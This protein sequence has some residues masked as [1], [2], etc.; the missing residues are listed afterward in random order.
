VTNKYANFCRKASLVVVA[1]VLPQASTAQW[2]DQTQVLSQE[3]FGYYRQGRVLDAIN[4]QKRLIEAIDSSQNIGAAWSAVE[5]MY[6][7]CMQPGMPGYSM[8][9]SDLECTN[10]VY[11][12]MVDLPSLGEDLELITSLRKSY[13]VSL[14]LVA[15]EMNEYLPQVFSQGM[16][17]SNDS[18][19]DVVYY[20]NRQLL[21]AEAHLAMDNSRRARI[22]LERALATVLSIENAHNNIYQVSRWLLGISN[23]YLELNDIR[24][25]QALFATAGP[26][27]VSSFA[28]NSPDSLAAYAFGAR[29]F[30]QALRPEIALS[31]IDLLLMAVD[32]IDPDGDRL[33]YFRDSAF[34]L[35]IAAC[36]VSDNR[37]CMTQA[38]SDEKQ[39]ARAELALSNSDDDFYYS[40]LEFVAARNIG[41][42]MMGLTN[43]EPD[44]RKT[45]TFYEKHLPIEQIPQLDVLIR[46]ALGLSYL[47]MGDQD[48]AKE[49][50]T[51]ATQSSISQFRRDASSSLGH[52]P[53]PPNEQLIMWMMALALGIGADIEQFGDLKNIIKTGVRVGEDYKDL[54]IAMAAGLERSSLE[55]EG[56]SL[57]VIA[58]ANSAQDRQLA[59]MYLRTVSKQRNTYVQLAKRL[60]DDV[61]AEA[62][63]NPNAG[64][65]SLTMD[66]SIRR[67]VSDYAQRRIELLGH[68][69]DDFKSISALPT[70]EDIQG[71]LGEKEALLLETTFGGARLVVCVRNDVVYLGGMQLANQQQ[72]YLDLRV[73][74]LA[75]EASHAPSEKLDRQFPASA[76][77]R[78]YEQLLGP[79]EMC[80]IPGDTVYVAAR[81][82]GLPYEML[83]EY[84]PSKLGDGF[85]L[86]TAPWALNKYNFTYVGTALEFVAG[87]RID[88]DSGASTGFLGVGNPT[89]S[90][91]T[92]DGIDRE[93]LVLRGALESASESLNELPPLPNTL[94][95]LENIL[96]IMNGDGTVITGDSATEMTLRKSGVGNFEYLSF[97]THGLI[98][99][100]IAGLTEAA[101]VLTPIDSS[102][103]SN[104]GLLTAS[105]IADMRL[106]ARVAVLSACNT[107]ASDIDLVHAE[108]QSL[109]AAFLSSRR[110]RH[111]SEG[112]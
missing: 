49:L 98:T 33:S 80:L 27:I 73:I 12:H 91:S 8:G 41:R 86:S 84:E 48:Q 34:S 104:D 58:S 78:L 22:A 70:A 51:E 68:L 9:A 60:V 2:A 87:R 36:V 40:L 89:L 37:E 19:F 107:T 53:V 76:A 31:Y 25:A 101:L 88:R 4:A 1:L 3:V 57:A 15:N 95:E 111:Q 108:M 54:V 63:R 18:P 74:K 17:E 7:L 43:S 23:L 99:S 82:D 64:Y 32:D 66:Y 61:I 100:E 83:L 50:V 56:D 96:T 35:K 106:N 72:H 46:F 105:E 112:L 6:Q 45:I 69:T 28:E 77:V 75:L 39:N 5:T 42:L 24:S 67:Y 21:A 79:A 59:H 90:G 14:P 93:Q 71:F 92:E 16:L 102:Q 26:L 13:F 52:V 20:V 38:L 47:E 97:A 81:S 109:S 30:F 85:D 62:Q 110:C 55:V 65:A 103:T 29:L 94:I 44:I 10:W 11:P